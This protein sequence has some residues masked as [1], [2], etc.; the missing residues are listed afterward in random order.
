M[1]GAAEAELGEGV[2]AE[3]LLELQEGFEA[4]GAEAGLGGTR[5]GLGSA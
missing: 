1:H 4:G 2:V 5:D 3:A